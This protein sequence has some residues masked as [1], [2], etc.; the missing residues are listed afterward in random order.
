VRHVANAH[1]VG[2]EWLSGFVVACRRDEK[3][4]AL[5]IERVIAR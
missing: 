3:P 1:A 5:A 2:I 4:P